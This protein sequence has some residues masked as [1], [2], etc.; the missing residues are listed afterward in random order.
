MKSVNELIYILLVD[1]GTLTNLDGQQYQVLAVNSYTM[2][3]MRK[4]KKNKG[5]KK[6]ISTHIP[7]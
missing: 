2:N 6:Q 7:L 1:I 4:P 3:T 5:N